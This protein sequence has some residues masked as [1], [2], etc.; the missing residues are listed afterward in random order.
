MQHGTATAAYRINRQQNSH[1]VAL[2][3]Q[4]ELE[5]VLQNAAGKPRKL[6]AQRWF[7]QEL[8]TSA[9]DASKAVRDMF[10][11]AKDNSKVTGADFGL[12]LMRP[13]SSLW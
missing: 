5:S 8:I 1:L 9:A 10:G 6:P 12:V 3:A 11:V 7:Q 2:K 4:G 13:A